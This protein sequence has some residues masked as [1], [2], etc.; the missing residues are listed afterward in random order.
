MFKFKP[1]FILLATISITS[2]I[3]SAEISDKE[4]NSETNEDKKDSEIILYLNNSNLLASLNLFPSPFI[5]PSQVDIIDEGNRNTLYGTDLNNVGQFNTAFGWRALTYGQGN[6]SYNTAFG[7]SALGD[8]TTCYDSVAVGSEAGAGNVDGGGNIFIGYKAGKEVSGG[9]SNVVI[10]NRAAWMQ[11]LGRNNILIGT[12]IET[13]SNSTGNIILGQ[14]NT[15]NIDTDSDNNNFIVGKDGENLIVGNFS[16]GNLILGRTTGTITA[17]NDFKVTNDL[18]IG[19]IALTNENGTLTWNGSAVGSGGSSSFTGGTVANSTSFSSDVGIDG[20]LDVNTN[21][22]TVAAASGNTGIAGTLAVTG[23]TTLSNTLTVAGTLTASGDAYVTGT[24]YVDNGTSLADYISANSSSSNNGV[25]AASGTNLYAGQFA[26]RKLT[27]GTANIAMG[28]YSLEENTIGSGNIAIGTHSMAYNV[29]GNNNVAIGSSSLKDNTVGVENIAIGPSTLRS[30]TTGS[31]NSVLGTYAM[32]KNTEGSQNVAIGGGSLYYNTTGTRNVAVGFEALKDAVTGTRNTAI[33]TYAGYKSTGSYNV[34][35][36]YGAGELE[37]GDNK[38][39]ISN[40]KETNLITGDFS[41]GLLNLGQTSG[42][43]SVLNNFS[44]AGDATFSSALTTSGTFTAS[45]DAYVTGTLYVD[46][47]TSLADYISNYVSDNSNSGAITYNSSRKNLYSVRA[48]DNGAVSGS[49]NIA[50]GEDA[51]EA[52]QNGNDNIAIGHSANQSN[53]GSYN[54]AIGNDALETMTAG[55]SNTAVG[56]NA[57]RWSKGDDNTAL[58]SSAGAG[59]SGGDYN[60]YIGSS[61]GFGINGDGNVLIGYKAGYSLYEDNGG[62]HNLSNKLYISNDANSNLITGDFSNGSLNLGQTS[63]TVAILNNASIAGTLSLGSITD[64]ASLIN[65]NSTVITN[66]SSGARLFVAG[67]NLGIGDNTLSTLTSGTHN[68]SVGQES[69]ASNTTGQRNVS[70]G[71]QAMSA[72][73]QGNNNNAMGY[74]ALY[75]NTSGSNNTAQGNSALLANTSGSNN[76]GFG[77]GVLKANTTGNENSAFGAGAMVKNTTGIRN[78]AVG[79]YALNNNI[80]GSNNVAIGYKAGRDNNGDNNIFI[81]KEACSR[82]TDASNTFC[83][84][85][86]NPLMSGNFSSNRVLISG[87][88][89][90]TGDLYVKGTIY[91]NTSE[92]DSFDEVGEIASGSSN[93]TYLS[94]NE[95]SINNESSSEVQLAGTSSTYNETRDSYEEVRDDVYDG[96]ESDSSISDDA[97]NDIIN[98]DISSKIK[99]K[100]YS[101]G[102]DEVMAEA[103]YVSLDQFLSLSDQVSSM[104]N[105]IDMLSIALE[106]TQHQMREGFAMSSALAAMPTP[107]DMG[108]NFSA[109]A[110]NYDGANAL[111][112][113]F[114]YVKE[115]FVINFGHAKS[116][117]GSKSMT[118]IGFTYNISNWFKK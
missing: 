80:S 30:N 18:Y 57:L 94:K 25:M 22:F 103:D 79:T 1:I 24:L 114:V 17:R 72:N 116:D 46:N 12:M 56:F 16:T 107:T 2:Y 73:T 97:L 66:I 48:L 92:A 26:L 65:S 86:Q 49:Y 77:R 102:S 13:A 7:V 44:V 51:M 58:G 115:D 60:T 45:G 74:R 70:V 76:S 50:F 87:S 3:S 69:L 5:Q 75:R 59:A 52:N 23:A 33:G 118:N 84:G 85:N 53:D 91:E 15:A 4:K 71:H 20:D 99:N 100:T 37:S 61:A 43:V 112:I 78:S 109:G 108:L 117:T 10:G 39:Y 101:S 19:D 62:P 96:N 68:I 6:G 64:V 38:L 81:G 110:G 21:K 9:N 95:T 32:H 42:T 106:D 54:V 55:H 90:V 98:S 27:T 67:N 83:I 88:L 63:G 28:E 113:G 11:E 31:R 34:F 35:I 82:L 29:S 41:T 104:G 93:N 105:R 8:C 111:A 47:G 14:V 89:V 36:G 40:S